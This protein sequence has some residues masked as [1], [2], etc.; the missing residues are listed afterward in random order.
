MIRQLE[1]KA[2]IQDLDPIKLKKDKRYINAIAIVN[3]N[4]ER[5][6]LKTNDEG[7]FEFNVV[8][9]NDIIEVSTINLVECTE[10]QYYY[11]VLCILDDTLILSRKFEKY[12]EISY[13]KKAIILNSRLNK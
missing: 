6:F 10:I 8:K 13:L 5:L 1:N 11:I 9:P 3:D 7:Y 4:E 12:K 2:L